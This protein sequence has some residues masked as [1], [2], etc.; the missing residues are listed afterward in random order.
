MSCNALSR[1]HYQNQTCLC[2]S[3][4]GRCP[5]HKNMA[6]SLTSKS[7][8]RNQLHLNQPIFDYLTQKNP[9]GRSV[10]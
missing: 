3:L 9:H 6:T 5:S 1:R 4:H 8:Q 7:G 2:S 10:K